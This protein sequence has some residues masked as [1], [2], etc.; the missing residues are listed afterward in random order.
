MMTARTGLEKA[1]TVVDIGTP[2]ACKYEIWPDPNVS[3]RSF[4]FLSDALLGTIAGVFSTRRV[5]A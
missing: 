2:E 5:H 1:M 3:F 4:S